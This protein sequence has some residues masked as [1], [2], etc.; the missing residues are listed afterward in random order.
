MILKDHTVL[1]WF[2]WRRS[3]TKECRDSNLGRPGVKRE[4]C[5]CAIV[6]LLLLTNPPFSNFQLRSECAGQAADDGG[7]RLLRPRRRPS[8]RRPILLRLE[9]EGRRRK[10]RFV[11]SF[12]AEFQELWIL[13]NFKTTSNVLAISRR[14]S[15]FCSW[16]SQLDFHSA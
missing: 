10:Q 11:L 12:A 8:A 16:M 3:R 9:E 2:D 4:F 13:W 7:R 5:H 14:D 6:S 15:L 1:Y